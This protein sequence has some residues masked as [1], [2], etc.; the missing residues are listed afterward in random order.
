MPTEQIDRLIADREI[1]HRYA[2]AIDEDEVDFPDDEEDDEE[3]DE[4][5]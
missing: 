4:E 5:I 3:L 1:L 2:M